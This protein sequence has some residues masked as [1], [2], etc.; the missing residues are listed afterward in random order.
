MPAYI[1]L[2]ITMAPAIVQVSDLNLIGIHL[3]LMYFSV[4]SLITLPVAV[5]AFVASTIAQASPMAT[6]A[7]AMRLG[8]VIYFVP[9]FFVYNPSLILQGGNLFETFYLVV[10]CIIGII[11]ITG[12]LE[13]FLLKVGILP[14][15]SRPLLVASGFLIALPGWLTTGIGVAGAVLLVMI[16]RSLRKRL[17]TQLVPVSDG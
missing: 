15:W 4:V 5:G 13:G 16:L 1:F 10:L 11:F 8:V 12:G 9:F 7:R 17:D 3:F 2:A 14:F 6:A